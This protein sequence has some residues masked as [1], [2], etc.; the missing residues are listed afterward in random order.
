MA[1]LFMLPWC[2]PI[3]FPARL[4]LGLHGGGCLGAQKYA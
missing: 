2:P 3:Q 4:L 1:V